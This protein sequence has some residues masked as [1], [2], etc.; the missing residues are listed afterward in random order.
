MVKQVQNHA[1][2]ARLS[3]RA[4][5]LLTAPG[6]QFC[7]G[8]QLSPYDN[9]DPV[10]LDYPRLSLLHELAS[11][12]HET[13][14]DA[15]QAVLAVPGVATDV[16]TM[17]EFAEALD[18]RGLL[19]PNSGGSLR[20]ATEVARH[21]AG[22]KDEMPSSR[23]VA[24]LPQVFSLS[25]RGFQSVDHSGQL[26]AE[27]SPV[28]LMAL[29]VFW[30]P[31]TWEEGFA[32][33][34][35][36]CGSGALGGAEFKALVARLFA[37]G[38][39]LNVSDDYMPIARAARQQEA[40]Q[41]A[42]GKIKDALERSL[43]EHES[44]EAERRRRTGVNR[45]RVVPV[46]RQMTM[47]P[48]A[49]GMIVAAARSFK[50]GQLQEYYDFVPD[51]YTHANRLDQYSQG[52]G[53]YLFSDYVWSTREN[54]ALS[55]RV[56]KNNPLSVTVH[57]GP[58]TPRRTHDVHE[59]FRKFPHIDIVVHGEGEETVA[60]MLEHLVGAFDGEQVDLSCLK[61]VLGLSY[62]DGNEII[63]NPPRPQIA[64]IDSIPSPFLDGTFD[65]YNGTMISVSL[66]TNRGCPYG[67]TFCDWGAATLSKV[68]KFSLERV[69]A[70]M[71]WCA[72][73]GVTSIGLADANFGMLD[74][75][76]QIAEK[77]AQLKRDYGYPKYFGTN[78]AKNKI[79]HL[80]PI[81]EMLASEGII[82]EGLM[83]LQS[84]DPHT[85]SVIDR[86]NIKTEKYDELAI[87]FRKAG[88]PLLVDIMMGLPGSTPASFRNDLQQCIDRE[89]TAKV[90]QTE[91]LVNSPM[92]DPEYRKKHQIQTEVEEVGLFKTKGP[93][94][95][96]LGRAMVVATATFSRQDY[97]QMLDLRT[98]YR[99]FE[100]Y[101]LLRH[102][103]RFLRQETGQE[104]IELVE[105][106][107]AQ[108]RAAPEKWPCINY[109]ISVTPYCITPPVSWKWFM[110]EMREFILEK[111][112]LEDDAALHT[113][114]EVQHG[115][116]P[117]PERKFPVKLNLTH[118][119]ASWHHDMI[120]AKEVDRCQWH[121]MIPRLRDYPAGTLEITDPDD[122][123]GM[124]MGVN[125]ENGLMD[126]LELWSSVSRPMSVRHTELAE[127]T[128]IDSS[129]F[130]IKRKIA[131]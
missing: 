53:V 80:R 90:F 34:Q 116:L 10:P 28:E 104:E 29:G 106:I 68:R 18:A 39:L 76:V 26:R 37:T 101:N 107:R 8:L 58:D 25:E 77:V 9:S 38:R 102:V 15:I 131:S 46:L 84:M 127:H 79:K 48:L 64:D 62:R 47:A 122:I 40:L 75:D 129:K 72:Q 14:G 73:N 121:S 57:G 59:F 98:V 17:Q 71:E 27:V 21:E 50:G 49:L 124:S 96:G 52:P 115:L 22:E 99:F 119:Y 56:K 103:L 100:N 78:F 51:W 66:E 3:R 65:N 95:S 70:E 1:S 89:V 93:N 74:R 85:L 35:E 83:S 12:S 13:L 108:A 88:L 91:L 36:Q 30:N 97:D 44:A 45:I 23:V 11:G 105:F 33:H 4:T 2:I 54:M 94:N 7:A 112:S 81:I 82:T 63:C 92:N 69:F 87:E 5:V 42:S 24:L 128:K 113:V 20:S 6:S 120:V 41:K 118:D 67:C 126:S 61:G 125:N 43:E 19:V 111:F 117:S 109:T 16:S 86:S 31:V 130:S 55:N 32:T 123:C 114:L 110:D 60:H